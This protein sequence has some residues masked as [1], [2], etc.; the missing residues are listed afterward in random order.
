MLKAR[1]IQMFLHDITNDSTRFLPIRYNF[2][3]PIVQMIDFLAEVP[4]RTFSIKENCVFS[5]EFTFKCSNNFQLKHGQMNLS[6]N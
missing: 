2:S 5:L 1:K 3:T 6:C 4:K